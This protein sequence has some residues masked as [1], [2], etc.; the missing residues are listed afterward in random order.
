M[1]KI[2][3]NKLIFFQNN[4]SI[5]Y[6]YSLKWIVLYSV[7]LLIR[8][9]G[10]YTKIDFTQLNILLS[11]DCIIIYLYRV[12]SLKGHLRDYCSMSACI[13]RNTIYNKNTLKG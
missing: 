4:K 6:R 10:I 11:Y 3:K 7:Y 8:D 2:V 1:I 9:K 5:L 13:G 12:K